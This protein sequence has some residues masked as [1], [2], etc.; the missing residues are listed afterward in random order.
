MK[1]RKIIIV[2]AILVSLI[3]GCSKITEGEIYKK[4]FRA[5]RS[6]IQM[7]P[8]VHT[9]G[10]S[11]WISYIPIWHH[12]PDEYII[13]IRDLETDKTALY[14]VKRETYEQCEI[15]RMFKYEPQRGD[16]D[17]EPITKRKEES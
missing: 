16:L 2:L 10:E 8:M 15:G 4:E 6:W 13:G 5:E 12:H 11:T 1:C 9:N 17:K 7:I 14:Y 3:T